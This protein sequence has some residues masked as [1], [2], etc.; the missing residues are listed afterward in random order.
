MRKSVS[1]CE[2]VR[3]GVGG[4]RP[5]DEVICVSMEV[6]VRGVSKRQT[7]HE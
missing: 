2:S 4:I 7:E 6:N 5:V 1:V 3:E